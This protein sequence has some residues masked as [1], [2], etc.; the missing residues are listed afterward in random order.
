MRILVHGFANP[1]VA[2]Y[3]T[4]YAEYLIFIWRVFGSDM[5]YQA[6]MENIKWFPN[7]VEYEFGKPQPDLGGLAQLG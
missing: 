3:S 7:D 6:L 4:D 1:H 5:H 2:V